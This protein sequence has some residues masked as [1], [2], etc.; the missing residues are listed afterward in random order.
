MAR[1]LPWKSVK[2]NLLLALGV[3]VFGF[4][5]LN[6]TFIFDFIFQSL[7]S[8][9]INLVIPSIDLLSYKEAFPFMHLSFVIVIIFISWKIF[10]SKLNGFVKATFMTVPLAVIYVTISILAYPSQMIAYLLG[11]LFGIGVFVYLYYSKQPWLY[12]FALILISLALLVGAVL[13]M[14]I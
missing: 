6:L 12:Y 10:T 5:L 8:A 1:N 2:K 3:A 14:E 4:I 13:G 9:L 7:I 11:G